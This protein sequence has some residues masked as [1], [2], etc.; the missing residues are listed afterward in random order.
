M[1]NVID[2]LVRHQTVLSLIFF[3]EDQ[4]V[5][6]TRVVVYGAHALPLHEVDDGVTAP[7]CGREVDLPAVEVLLGVVPGC[8]AGHRPSQV[9]GGLVLLVT[10][11]GSLFVSLGVALGE[12]EGRVVLVYLPD[13]LVA[14]IIEPLRGPYC[15]SSCW[16]V[17]PSWGK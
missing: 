5:E 15:R 13:G 3:F 9:K 1:G 12:H 8:P 6:V 14:A 4:A 11:S 16:D 10:R 7:C 2:D 17:G